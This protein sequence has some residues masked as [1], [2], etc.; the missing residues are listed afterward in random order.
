[1]GSG[2]SKSSE[3]GKKA[4]RECSTGNAPNRLSEK[5]TSAGVDSPSTPLRDTNYPSPLPEDKDKGTA[6]GGVARVPEVVRKARRASLAKLNAR[7]GASSETSDGG[8]TSYGADD[9]NEKKQC[10]DPLLLKLDSQ[11]AEVEFVLRVRLETEADVEKVRASIADSI[12]FLDELSRLASK[13][14]YS[15]GALSRMILPY[16]TNTSV[17]SQKAEVSPRTL[18][19][20]GRCSII[21]LSCGWQGRRTRCGASCALKSPM[22]PISTRHVEPLSSYLV[23]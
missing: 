9:D 16:H 19:L 13:Y 3:R 4:S 1:M 15:R 6:K 7:F 5:L 18:H 12:W 20:S 17:S 10:G 22:T 2:K 23:F 14:G 8:G 11:W 21:A